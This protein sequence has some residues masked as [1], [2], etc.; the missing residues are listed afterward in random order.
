MN[1]LPASLEAKIEPEPMSGCWL[2]TACRAPNGYGLVLYA[3]KYQGAHRAVYQALVG[4][5]PE[6]LEIDHLCRNRACVNP[7]HL[8]AV[9]HME[10][11]HRRLTG[12]TA[13]T[14]CPQ[15]HPYD[16]ENT[17]VYDNGKTRR[18]KCRTCGR[19]DVRSRRA[20]KT[21]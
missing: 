14:Q 4:P 5:I 15:G 3:G 16:E 11:M 8:E 6:G 10:N 17:S 7:M 12:S 20:R 1:E 21:V 19:E 2:W 13:K 9:T 18:R